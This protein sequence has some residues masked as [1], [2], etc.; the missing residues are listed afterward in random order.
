MPWQVAWTLTG[1]KL[2]SLIPG[3]AATAALEF[4]HGPLANPAA[5]L[6][7]LADAGATSKIARATTRPSRSVV[8]PARGC[9]QWRTSPRGSR[10]RSTAWV[11]EP[12]GVCPLHEFTGPSPVPLS[13]T[14]SSALPSTG[15]VRSHPS[16]STIPAA[17]TEAVWQRDVSHQTR[18][19]MSAVQAKGEVVRAW[20]ALA[21]DG[22]TIA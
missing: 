16:A 17:P 20:A 11:E 21:P 19:T 4:L 12:F 22:G 6:R 1:T 2:L 8:A 14:T 15:P 18:R 7:R 9:P 10:A 3:K 13:P 5:E